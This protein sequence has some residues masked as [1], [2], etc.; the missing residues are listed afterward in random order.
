VKLVSVFNVNVDVGAICNEVGICVH[1]VGPICNVCK[2]L[3]VA[4]NGPMLKI[5]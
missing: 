5:F 2:V 3:I 1:Y 4:P